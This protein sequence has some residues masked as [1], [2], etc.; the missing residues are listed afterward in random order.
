M[1]ATLTAFGTVQVRFSNPRQ[2]AQNVYMIEYQSPTN[3][4]VAFYQV[5]PAGN[6]GFMI[7]MRTGGTGMGAGLWEKR[8]AEGMAVA[9]SLRCQVPFVPPAPDP[10]GLN[11]KPASHS[12]SA[13]DESDTL[14]NTWLEREYYHNSET[15]ENLLGKPQRGDYS[16]KPRDPTALATTPPTGT[17]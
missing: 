4:G 1:A 9:R 15:G 16:G 11:S 8:G 12:S 6:G 17:A 2:L 13:N 7:V 10:P 3:H 14:Y 5:I